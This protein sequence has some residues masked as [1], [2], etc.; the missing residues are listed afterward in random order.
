MVQ[1]S[2]SQTSHRLESGGGTP[3]HRKLSGSGGEAPSRRAIF[4]NFLGK[5][6][7]LMLF[8]HNLHVSRA[9]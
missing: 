2:A 3:S 6:A 4:C 5:L 8:D 9:T 1:T 7:I